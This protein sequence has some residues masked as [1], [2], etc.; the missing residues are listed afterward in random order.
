MDEAQILG[1][2]TVIPEIPGHPEI[3]AIVAD[4]EWLNIYDQLFE[5]SDFSTVKSSTGITGCMYG[6]FTLPVLSI[7][8]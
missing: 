8:R 5:T 2:I 6:R 1:R 4:D 7:T 3:L